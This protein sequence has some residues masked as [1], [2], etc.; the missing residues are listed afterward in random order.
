MDSVLSC[1]H[2][3]EQ[4]SVWLECPLLARNTRSRV[5]RS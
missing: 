1:R 5:V 4:T 3:S 2:Q